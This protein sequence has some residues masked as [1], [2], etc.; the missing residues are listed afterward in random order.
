MKLAT[1]SR[2]LVVIMPHRANAG[3]TSVCIPSVLYGVN[4]PKCTIWAFGP[5]HRQWHHKTVSCY[6]H[7]CVFLM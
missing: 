7:I 4:N 6:S 3:E 5:I 1:I 2:V